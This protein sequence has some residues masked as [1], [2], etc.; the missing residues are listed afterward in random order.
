MRHVVRSYDPRRVGNPCPTTGPVGMNTPVLVAVDDDHDLLR[1][2]E[3]ELRNRYA[4]DYRS[5]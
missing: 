2:V 5:S 1:D 3:R 4:S